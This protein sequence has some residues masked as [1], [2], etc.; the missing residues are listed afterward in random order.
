MKNTARELLY[1]LRCVWPHDF[2]QGGRRGYNL[3]KKDQTLEKRH[4]TQKK[5]QNSRKRVHNSQISRLRKIEK[6]YHFYSRE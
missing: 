1:A 3:K 6:R 4:N 2:S 5:E